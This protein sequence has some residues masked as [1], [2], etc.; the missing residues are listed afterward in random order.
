MTRMRMLSID[1]SLR[2][3]LP[4][5]QLLRNYCNVFGAVLEKKNISMKMFIEIFMKMFIEIFMKMFIEI[6]MK[7]F[8]EVNIHENVH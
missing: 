2:K 4:V 8:I 6:F 1:K 3:R 5:F 7:M